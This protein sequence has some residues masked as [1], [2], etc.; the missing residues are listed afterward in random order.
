MILCTLAESE[1][2]IRQE[3]QKSSVTLEP[4]RPGTQSSNLA[5]SHQHYLEELF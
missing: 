2:A 3:D 5:S 1:A 4:I